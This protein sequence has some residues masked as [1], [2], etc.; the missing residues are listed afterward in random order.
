MSD[1]YQTIFNQRGRSYH[2]AMSAVPDARLNEFA[3]ILDIANP[4]PGEVICDM[5]AG[6][7]YLQKHLAGLDVD[8]IS[9]E[10]SEVFHELCKEKAKGTSLLC[11]LDDTPLEDGSVDLVIS[12]A[13]L[14]H[15]EDRRPFYREA[16][17]ILKPGGRLAIADVRRNSPVDS[18]LNVFVH[19]HSS[20]GHTGFFF[21][22]QTAS[23]LSE[24]G[25][26]VQVCGPRRYTW[27]FPSADDMV[28]YCGHLFGIDRATRD[29]IRD[30]IE[31]HVG[32]EE[33][34]DSCRMDWELMAFGCRKPAG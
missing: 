22:E 17:R 25:F 34:P 23:E 11:C 19:E 3:T 27:D 7:G 21:D 4:A 16:F 26:R 30:G 12:L 10:T 8:L 1:E 32:Y 28:S 2:E 9:V 13:G 31:R 14:H 29:R 20:L 5:P 33:G 18:L 15:T 6:G 24:V